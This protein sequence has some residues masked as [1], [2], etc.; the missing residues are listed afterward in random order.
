[1]SEFLKSFRGRVKMAPYNRKTIDGE[2]IWRA[3]IIGG[4]EP[5]FSYLMAIGIDPESASL[6]A[7]LKR[8]Q[9]VILSGESYSQNKQIG[10]GKITLIR[11]MLVRSVET[12]S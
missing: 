7:S 5:N 2:T 8:N 4:R 12:V 9:Q 10:H 6:V 1:M 11:G 3:L